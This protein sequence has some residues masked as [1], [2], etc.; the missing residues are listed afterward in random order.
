METPVPSSNPAVP[1]VRR[2][3]LRQAF[4][5][6]FY[7]SELYRDIGRNWRGIGLLYLFCLLLLAAIP[8]AVKTHLGYSQWVDRDAR[9]TVD[10]IPHIAIRNGEVSTDVETPYYIPNPEVGRTGLD[11]NPAYLAVIDLT[12]EYES[13]EDV[14]ARIL[15]T[16]R[17]ISYHNRN[18]FRTYDLSGVENFETD[19]AQVQGWLE[20]ARYFIAPAS[21]MGVLAFTF[22]YRLAQVAIYA[23]IGLLFVKWKKARL[24]YPAVMRLAA[25]AV[26]PALVLNELVYIL[27]LQIP[28]W[29]LTCFGIAMGYL[30]FAVGAN[31]EPE[32]GPP[33]PPA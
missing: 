8:A 3:G 10:K 11:A 20:S 33:L 31:A 1:P 26:T 7:S 18:E 5:L 13:L 14:D 22:V 23:A 4:F 29:S 9:E 21:Y 16:D 30:V 27:G 25:V 15:L 32:T 17:S 2:F 6:S 24:E 19:A 28:L 12:G